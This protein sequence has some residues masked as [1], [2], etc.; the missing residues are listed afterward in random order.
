M[1]DEKKANV[2][3]NGA[4]APEIELAK[5]AIDEQKSN[6][7]VSPASTAGSSGGGA[8]NGDLKETFKAFSKFGDT[9]SDGKLITLSQSDKWMKQAKVIDK[10]ITTT[11]TAIHFKKLKSMKIS[12][13]DYNK[14]L[15]DLTTTKKVDIA[16][17][18]NKLA[19]CGAPGINQ[20]SSVLYSLFLYLKFIYYI[21][22]F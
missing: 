9:K 6:G 2:S 17:I 22:I 21:K 3:A 15:D 4:S 18:K 20:V 8:G 11:D 12:Y 1:S 14:F 16:E 5:L 19:N 10:K 7:S 13:A